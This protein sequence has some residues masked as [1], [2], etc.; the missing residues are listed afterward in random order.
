MNKNVFINCPYDDDYT[1]ILHAV[2]FVICCAGFI[3]RSAL[4]TKESGK[5]RLA[6]IVDIIYQCRLGIHDIS[7]VESKGGTTG[8]LPRFNMPFEFGLFY[9]ALNFGTDD[10]KSKL[11]LVLD[12]DHHRYQQTLS[13]IAGK[14]PSAHGN[15]PERAIAHVREFLSDKNGSGTLPG[16]EYFSRCYKK[17]SAKLPSIAKKLRI[18]SNEIKRREYW[19]DYASCA[20]EWVQRASSQPPIRRS[21]TKRPIA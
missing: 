3:P 20:N 14:D 7:R 9:G 11:M 1:D 16:A 18:S 12:S 2:T 10:Q 21:R 4:E 5:E 6:K 13:D 19:R 8:D 17:F 15:D